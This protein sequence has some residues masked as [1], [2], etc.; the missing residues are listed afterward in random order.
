MVSDMNKILEINKDLRMVMANKI[1]DNGNTRIPDDTL[2]KSA[3]D[4]RH[5]NPGL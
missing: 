2:C 4:L 3:L 1:D 5:L